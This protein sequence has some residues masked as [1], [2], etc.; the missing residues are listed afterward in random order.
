MFEVTLK[1]KMTTQKMT[2]P[3]VVPYTG[4]TAA[5]CAGQQLG[6]PAL[7]GILGSIVLPDFQVIPP[8]GQML[9]KS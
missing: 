7:I 4:N 5:H 3:R 1:D 2:V 6:V 9:R 8:N